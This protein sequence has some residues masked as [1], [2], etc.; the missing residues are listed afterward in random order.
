MPGYQHH[1]LSPAIHAPALL[2]Q[3][4]RNPAT[5]KARKNRRQKHHPEAI[6]NVFHL[7]AALI[8]KYFGNHAR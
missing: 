8:Y 4:S 5:K 3:A 2:D 1:G 7:I 6:A